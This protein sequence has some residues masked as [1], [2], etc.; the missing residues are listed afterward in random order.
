MP[1]II[2]VKYSPIFAE[3][4]INKA[5]INFD[6]S[7]ILVVEISEKLYLKHTNKILILDFQI[8]LIKRFCW[9]G[10]IQ[11]IKQINFIEISYKDYL[12]SYFIEKI[13]RSVLNLDM[14]T[15]NSEDI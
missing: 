1:S 12:D 7:E 8:N 13:L 5:K 14:L 11:H 15:N 6:F 4:S 9:R 2:T 3:S 10:L